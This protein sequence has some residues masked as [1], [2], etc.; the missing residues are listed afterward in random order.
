MRKGLSSFWGMTLLHSRVSLMRNCF[1]RGLGFRVPGI[2]R[3]NAIQREALCNQQ[4]FEG[5]K[6]RMAPV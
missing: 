5:E 2:V 6:L 3:Q 1:N 4:H